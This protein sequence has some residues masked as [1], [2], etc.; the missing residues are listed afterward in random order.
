MF[1]AV[2]LLL[3]VIFAFAPKFGEFDTEMAGKKIRDW[4]KF[5]FIAVLITTFIIASNV[6]KPL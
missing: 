2:V 6:F 4:T 3:G 1:W 5:S